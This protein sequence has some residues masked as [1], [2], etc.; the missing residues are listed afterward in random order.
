MKIKLIVLGI[1]LVLMNTHF[2]TQGAGKVWLNPYNI[3][4][5]IRNHDP[6]PIIIT[7][8]H[9]DATP[10]AVGTANPLFMLNADD[11]IIWQT[12]M[13]GKTGATYPTLA[14]PL[15]IRISSVLTVTYTDKNGQQAF[16]RYQFPAGKT[17]FVAWENNTLRPQKGSFGNTQSG[18]SLRK[19]VRSSDIKSLEQGTIRS[20]VKFENDQDDE[21][22]GEL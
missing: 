1:V 13:N 18:M 12:T 11:S 22:F 20:A 16:K 10:V 19:N 14:T 6:R 15:D 2:A 5:E 17:I 7:L 8:K 4:F 9:D 21:R 3:G